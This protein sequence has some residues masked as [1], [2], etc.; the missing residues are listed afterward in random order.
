M[1]I[2]F[3]NLQIIDHDNSMESMQS[4]FKGREVSSACTVTSLLDVVEC[5][6]NKIAGEDEIH[7]NSLGNIQRKILGHD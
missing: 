1:V 6:Y 4:S 7:D 3:W 2:F 5:N